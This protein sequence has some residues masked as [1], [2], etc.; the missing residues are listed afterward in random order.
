MICFH[1]PETGTKY[2]I[3]WLNFEVELRLELSFFAYHCYYV[4]RANNLSQYTFNEYILS[5]GT[6]N[7]IYS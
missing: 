7:S 1:E 2:Y 3:F 6:Y 4:S 5:S